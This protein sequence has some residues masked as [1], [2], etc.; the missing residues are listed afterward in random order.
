MVNTELCKGCKRCQITEACPI[1]AASVADGKLYIDPQKCNHCG[2]C[3]TKCPFHAVDDS[4]PGYA[5]VIGGRWGKKMAQGQQLTKLF[6]SEAEV[7]SVVEKTIL[8]FA[9]QGISG[10]RLSD[11]VAR[12]GF[13]KV[14]AELLSDEIL[15]RKETIVEKARTAKGGAT[16]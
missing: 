8:F 1:K 2:R 11:T 9:E 4:T 10:E 14:N 6:T 3:V 16:C 13:E 12:I 5:I 7:I 15:S